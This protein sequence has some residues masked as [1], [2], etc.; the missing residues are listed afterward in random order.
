M[1]RKKFKPACGTY[2]IHVSGTCGIY[3]VT[4][5]MFVFKVCNT[6]IIRTVY[7]AH[8]KI[9]LATGLNY[10]CPYL[11]PLPMSLIYTCQR[12]GLFFGAIFT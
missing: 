7:V 3:V 11:Y 4:Y 1:M 6:H 9:I 12:V 5:G 10:N 8:G 2:E